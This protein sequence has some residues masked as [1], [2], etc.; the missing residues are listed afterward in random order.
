M[1]KK[2]RRMQPSGPLSSYK[3]EFKD[4]IIFIVERKMGKTRRT[5]LMDLARRKGFRVENVLSDSVTHIVAENNSCAEI[6]KWLEMQKVENNSNLRLLDISWLTACMEVGRPVDPEKFQ[7]LVKEGQSSRVEAVLNNDYYRTFKLFTSVF[8]VG[9][10][11]SEKWYRMGLRTLE[12]VKCDKDI[13]LTRMQ[14]A[15]FLYYEDL[16]SCVSKAEAD[17]VTL[18]V[19]E[20]AWKF[21][22]SALVTLTG[23]FRR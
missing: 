4:I 23:G 5:F 9:L 19:K 14:K 6:L 7:L 10:K 12:E 18:F 3:I 15:G 21:C 16:I 8:G 11:T 20:C 13:K 2:Q 22:P 17:S 1:L